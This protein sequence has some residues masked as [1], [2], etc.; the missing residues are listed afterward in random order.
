MLH[1]GLAHI[2]IDA[3]DIPLALGFIGD[4][5]GHL[6]SQL[7]LAVDH[8]GVGKIGGITRLVIVVAV[9]AQ[10]GADA[11]TLGFQF[12]DDKGVT[13]TDGG[14]VQGAVNQAVSLSRES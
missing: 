11:R 2:D 6:Q 8:E 13:A 10:Q 7:C 9:V 1:K 3:P 4:A 12:A 14:L 5:V